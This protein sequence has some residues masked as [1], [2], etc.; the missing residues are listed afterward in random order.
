MRHQFYYI[1]PVTKERK[2]AVINWVDEETRQFGF[3]L[4]DEYP[5]NEGGDVLSFDDTESYE[6]VRIG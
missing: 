5:W 2:S 4:T 6:L 1:T 3:T